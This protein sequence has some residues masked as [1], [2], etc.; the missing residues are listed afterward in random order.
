MYIR[1]CNKVSRLL[2]IFRYNC[3]KTTTSI[4]ILYSFLIIHKRALD[5]KDPFSNHALDNIRVN[6]L[7]RTNIKR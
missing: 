7:V 3:N 5:T 4:A 2:V 1:T 6:R